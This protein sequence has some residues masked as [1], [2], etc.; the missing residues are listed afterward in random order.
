MGPP[1][2]H[3]LFFG[4]KGGSMIVDPQL[5]VR[6]WGTSNREVIDSTFARFFVTD[7]SRSNTFLGRIT[8]MS[9]LCALYG[10]NPTTMAAET[11]IAIER[12]F[13]NVAEFVEATVVET[14]LV[15]DYTPGNRYGLKITV[16][17]V[18]NGERI[19]L[20]QELAI[21]DSSFSIV[22]DFLEGR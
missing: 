12:L 3:S 21:G 22:K 17:A 11:K 9:S 2:L 7:A 4:F 5:S 6:G 15:G 10:N 16:E 14:P 13:Q 8:S 1:L 18:L 20:L 19:N